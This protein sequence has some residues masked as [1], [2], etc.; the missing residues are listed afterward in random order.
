MSRYTPLYNAIASLYANHREPDFLPP[1]KVFPFK[2]IYRSQLEVMQQIPDGE[3]VCITSHTGWGKT[4]R[5]KEE[6]TNE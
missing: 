2:T 5:I 3:S 4:R 1:P 6:T